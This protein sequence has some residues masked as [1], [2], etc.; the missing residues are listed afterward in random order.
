MA[1][2]AQGEGRTPNNNTRFAHIVG[3]KQEPKD[4]FKLSG[5]AAW[6]RNKLR[7]MNLYRD[8]KNKNKNHV[9]TRRAVGVPAV[10]LVS[11][12]YTVVL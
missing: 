4:P 3:L 10:A 1:Y 7:L 8:K 11:V 6:P 12:V 5:T 9:I 2:R